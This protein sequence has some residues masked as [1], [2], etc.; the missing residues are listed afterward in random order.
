MSVVGDERT[1]QIIWL[2][3]E[4]IRLQQENLRLRAALEEAKL[5]LYGT[6]QYDDDP[7]WDAARK[8]EAALANEEEVNTQMSM[9]EGNTQ[10]RIDDAMV[11]RALRAFYKHSVV[12]NFPQASRNQ[13][14]AAL[15]AALAKRAY[16]EQEKAS[17]VAEAADAKLRAANERALAKAIAKQE[18]K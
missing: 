11:E 18:G 1:D 5:A 15:E 8:I 9:Q 16:N 6:A 14:T 3:G 4:R 12:Q 17:K 10:M 7:A 13:M 2:R